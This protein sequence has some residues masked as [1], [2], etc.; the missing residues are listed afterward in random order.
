MDRKKTKLKVLRANFTRNSNKFNQQFD[1]DDKDELQFLFNKVEMCF[2]NLEEFFEEII[3]DFDDDDYKKELQTHSTYEETFC[4]LKSKFKSISRSNSNSEK[5]HTIPSKLPELKIPTFNGNFLNWLEFWDM[6]NCTVNDN[7]SLSDVQ[8]F[9]Y[10]RSLLSG[11][12]ASVISG[13]ALTSENY[14]EAIKLLKNR[15]DK[16][17]A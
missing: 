3:N 9:T 8:K 12:A 13:L 14:N 15:F 4:D 5:K 2:D 10:L 11:N 6:F 1:K 17:H 16:N 7:M